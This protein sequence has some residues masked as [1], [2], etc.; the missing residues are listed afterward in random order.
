MLSRICTCS[1]TTYHSTPTRTLV[2]NDRPSQLKKSTVTE[3]PDIG[4]AHDRTTIEPPNAGLSK[5]PVG[6]PSKAPGTTH[7]ALTPTSS[8]SIDHTPSK[9]LAAMPTPTLTL[10]VQE[11]N[12]GRMCISQDLRHQTVARSYAPAG[13]ERV[14]ALEANGPIGHRDARIRLTNRSVAT[15]SLNA[16][17]NTTFEG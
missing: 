4:R 14:A 2:T 13:P 9:A 16:I 12:I 5:A 17:R 1:L 10:T 7:K 11:T 15:D 6:T 3:I 8:H